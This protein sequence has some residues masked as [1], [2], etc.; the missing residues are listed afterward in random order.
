MIQDFCIIA[1]ERHN[2]V[3]IVEYNHNYLIKGKLYKQIKISKQ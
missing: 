3:S 2:D 1:K